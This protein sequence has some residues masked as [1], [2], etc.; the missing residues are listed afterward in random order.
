M[1]SPWMNGSESSTPPGGRPIPGFCPLNGITRGRDGCS[2]F[3]ALTPKLSGGGR[4]R[5]ILE[6]LCSRIRLIAPCHSEPFP[7][8][9]MKNRSRTPPAHRQSR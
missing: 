4:V 9:Q 3:T 6:L 7:F 8:T 5:D 1:P 2:T